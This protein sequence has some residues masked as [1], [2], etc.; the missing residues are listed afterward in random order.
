MSAPA[1]A[2]CLFLK[3]K[4]EEAFDAYMEIIRDE[5]D[6]IAAAK[7]P[8]PPAH[9]RGREVFQGMKRASRFTGR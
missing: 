4:H 5:R 2:S 7:P 6:A 8:C 9:R 1:H 3:G